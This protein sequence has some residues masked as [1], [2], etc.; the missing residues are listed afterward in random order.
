MGGMGLKLMP[1]VMR[2]LLDPL[3]MSRLMAGTSWTHNYYNSPKIGY[4]LPLVAL[5]PPPPTHLYMPLMI[6]Q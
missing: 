1:V 5:P 3:G 4:N 2:H 6:L